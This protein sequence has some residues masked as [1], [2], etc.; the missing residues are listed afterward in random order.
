MGREGIQGSGEDP[1][2][3]FP[4]REDEEEEGASLFDMYWIY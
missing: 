3:G 1:R 4:S 2:K